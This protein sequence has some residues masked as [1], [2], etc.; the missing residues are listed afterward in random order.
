MP[1]SPFALIYVIVFAAGLYCQLCAPPS[2]IGSNG[3]GAVNFGFASG[4][5]PAG[6]ILGASSLGAIP[7][8]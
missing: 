5:S 8:T 6:C 4:F 3:A 7:P 1:S 2:L